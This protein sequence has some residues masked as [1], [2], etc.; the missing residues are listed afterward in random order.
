MCFGVHTRQ[1]VLTTGHKPV[2]TMLK[3]V[4]HHI[5]PVAATIAE[6]VSLPRIQK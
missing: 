4:D 2:S 6:R 3:A 5:S 1:L